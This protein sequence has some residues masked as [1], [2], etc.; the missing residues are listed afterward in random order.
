MEKDSPSHPEDRI[1]NHVDELA[2]DLALGIGSVDKRLDAWRNSLGELIELSEHAG[3][4]ELSSCARQ[5]S[6]SLEG[7]PSGAFDEVELRVRAGV[8]VLQRILTAEPQPASDPCA[9]SGPSAPIGVSE[10]LSLADDPEAVGDFVLESREHLQEIDLQLLTLES[11]SGPPEILHD[12]FRRFHTLKGLAGFLEFHPLREL[13]HA[14]ENLL[15]QAREAELSLPP[16]SI[17]LLFQ[18]TDQLRSD[19]DTVESS[20][21]TKGRPLFD[22]RSGLISRLNGAPSG[23]QVVTPTQRSTADSGPDQDLSHA[24]ARRIAA[25]R[26][27]PAKLDYLV[28]LAGELIVA[29]SQVAH[30]PEIGD[31]PEGSLAAKMSQFSRLT[32][33]IQASAMSLRMVPVEQLFDRMARLVRDLARRCGKSVHLETSGGETAVDR[34]VVELLADPMVHL[35]RNALDH[36]IESPE[37]RRAAG[38]P[39]QGVL[40]VEASHHAGHILIEISDDGRGLDRGRVRQKAEERGLVSVTQELT[41]SEVDDFIFRPG[42]STTR[43]VTDLSGRGVGL[44]VVR[45]CLMSVRGWVEV[46]SR[47]RHGVRIR[48]HIPLTLALIEGLTVVVGCERYVAPL[49][50]VHQIVRP[51]TEMISMIEGR[52]EAASVR[53]ELYPILRLARFFGVGGNEKELTDMFLILTRVGTKRFGLA[54]DSFVGKQ[55]VIVKPLAPM[56]GVR[57]AGIAGGTILGDGRVAL[58]L[59]LESLAQSA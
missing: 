19:V 13:A 54:V 28:E 14:V 38:K 37:E 53:D 33:E 17:E 2:L 22:D 55:D 48:M 26:V 7:P 8:A 49:A 57:P 35:I 15:N 44:D 50:A 31:H 58:I 32:Q 5:L 56:G 11:Q 25:T 10:S 52:Y 6:L 23:E 29:Q 16:H 43:E 4:H 36:G 1:K 9:A 59:D 45:R 18:S 40:T 46:S 39:P 3:L 27:D 30:A 12:L 47:E 41:P 51:S 34:A 20:I 42:F 24:P 21:G